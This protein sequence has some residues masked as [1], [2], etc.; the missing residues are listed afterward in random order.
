M[1][2]PALRKIDLA[3]FAVTTIAGTTEGGAVD[4]IGTAARFSLADGLT[5]DGAGNLFVADTQGHTVRKVVLSSLAVSTVVGN[6]TQFGVHL[7][8]LPARLT[9][10]QSLAA[11][12]TGA[13]VIA[14]E[15]ALLLATF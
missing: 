11:L 1:D 4:G 3:S 7:G 2:G 15:A 5:L 12:P 6:P 8:V 14:D 13:L 10:P 9:L